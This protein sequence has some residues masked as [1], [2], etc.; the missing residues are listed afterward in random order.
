MV[1]HRNLNNKHW[2]MHEYP[3]RC[4]QTWRTSWGMQKKNARFLIYGGRIVELS[5]GDFPANHVW[6]PE[7]RPACFR[8]W[9]LQEVFWDIEYHTPK[10]NWWEMSIFSALDGNCYW[11]PNNQKLP[12]LLRRLG[13]PGSWKM[14]Q[15][16]FSLGSSHS[17]LAPQQ[18]LLPFESWLLALLH[19]LPHQVAV[20]QDPIR[21]S[22]I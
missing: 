20:N 13:S 3:Q 9:V 18:G 7:G 2:A 21:S 19:S 10:R 17:F 16:Q 5:M 4:H 22:K 1:I 8:F 14:W 6:L 11:L 12:A 15:V